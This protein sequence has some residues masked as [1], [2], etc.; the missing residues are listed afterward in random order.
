MTLI[1]SEHQGHPDQPEADETVRVKVYI[2]KTV[3]RA[4][5]VKPLEL[6]FIYKKRY[7]EQSE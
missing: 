5:R 1:I 7:H 3:P 2:Q 4:K 6:R